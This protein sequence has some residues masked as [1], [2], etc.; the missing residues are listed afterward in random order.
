MKG[1]GYSVRKQKTISQKEESQP[2]P[3]MNAK[4]PKNQPLIFTDD[5]DNPTG[6]EKARTPVEEVRAEYKS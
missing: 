6:R 1:F 2:G 4:S 3:R 5:A